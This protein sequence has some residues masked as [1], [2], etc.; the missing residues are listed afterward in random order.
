M[1]HSRFHKEQYYTVPL[2]Y[3]HYFLSMSKKNSSLSPKVM[4]G[5]LFLSLLAM[6]FLFITI[7]KTGAAEER[8]TQREKDTALILEKVYQVTR[9]VY[10][11]KF[12]KEIPTTSTCTTPTSNEIC[13]TGATDCSGLVDLGAVTTD[14]KYLVSIPSDPTGA[15]TNGTGYF[16]SKSTNGRIT[17]CAP[18]A[19]QGASIQVIR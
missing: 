6:V 14:Q 19:E 5:V 3:L 1:L 10:G 18:S 13:K 4:L 17:V 11:G 7:S 8:N 2:P 15:S 16:I 9:E 12:P